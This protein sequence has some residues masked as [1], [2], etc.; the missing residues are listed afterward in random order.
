AL[1]V[2]FGGAMLL[3]LANEDDARI[4]RVDVDEG[5]K[6]PELL[7][8]LERRPPFAAVAADDGGHLGLEL[9]GDAERIVDDDLAQIIDTALERV[10]PGSGPL[11]PIGGADVE[12][13]KAIEVADE[14][15]LI[16]I[17]GEELRV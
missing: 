12:H 16:E 6:L 4:G 9:G 17:G 5:T 3:A 7:R 14:R 15:R 2:P 1:F 13:E 11:Q 10:E 8:I